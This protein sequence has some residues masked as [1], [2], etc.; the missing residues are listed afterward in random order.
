LRPRI[1]PGNC[2]PFQ[3]SRGD[4]AIGLP[5]QL[6]PAAVT[7]RHISGAVPPSGSQWHPQRVCCLHKEGVRQQQ[8]NLLGTFPYDVHKEIAQTFCMQV[9]QEL[10][11]G[12]PGRR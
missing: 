1:A 10:W 7:I 6:W 3:A 11:A 2:W 4:V 8:K 9:P 12:C 5:E